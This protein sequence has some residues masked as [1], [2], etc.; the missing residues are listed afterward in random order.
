MSHGFIYYVTFKDLKKNLS[1]YLF[2]LNISPETFKRYVD[3]S[4]A[5]FLYIY[6]YIYINDLHNIQTTTDK[7]NHHIP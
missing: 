5:R 2:D 4:H 3:D 1:L 7:H 6:I